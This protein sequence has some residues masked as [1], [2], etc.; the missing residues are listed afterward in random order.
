M[1]GKAYHFMVT[2]YDQAGNVS[3]PS[4][5]VSV[6]IPDSTPPTIPDNVTNSAILSSGVALTWT[7]ATDNVGVTGYQVARDSVILGQ[8]AT[9]TFTDTTTNAGTTYTYTVQAMDANGNS[10]GWSQPL[11]VTVTSQDTIAP[12]VPQNL[13]LQSVSTTQV[14]FTWTAATDNVGVTGYQVAR[15]SVALGQTATTTFTDTTISTS[16]TYSYTVQ[17]MDAGGNKSAWSQ[18]LQVTTPQGLAQL[19]VSTSGNG[20]I[21]SS[22]NGINCPKQN[23]T[24]TYPPGTVVTL[25]AAPGKGWSFDGWSGSCTGTALCSM[26]MNSTMTVTANFSKGSQSGSGGGSGNGGGSGGGGGGGGGKGKPK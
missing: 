7:A 21:T 16:M 19:T 18:P 20:S 26:T 2:A 13:T 8:T 6:I 25:T 3:D 17:A 10:S 22:P 11:Q 15:D 5:Q 23:C 14:A 24:A 12:T 1:D 9:T 4:E